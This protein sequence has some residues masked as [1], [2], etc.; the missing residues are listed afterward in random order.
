METRLRE[1]G[2]KGRPRIE[3]EEHIRKRREKREDLAGSD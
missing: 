1:H 2:G 3:W